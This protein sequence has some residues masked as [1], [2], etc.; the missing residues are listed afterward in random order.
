MTIRKWGG[1][2]SPFAIVILGLAPRIQQ[3]QASRMQPDATIATYIMA[4][5]RNGTLYLGVPSDLRARVS[6]H[7]QGLTEGFSKKYGCKNLVWY[8]AEGDEA[9]GQGLEARADRESNPE[10]LD[11]SEAF[12]DAGG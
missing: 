12:W 3:L 9:L 8:E 2:H 4:S 5:G 6:Q 7:K 1:W 11:L 10:W